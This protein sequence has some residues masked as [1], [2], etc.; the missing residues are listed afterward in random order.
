MTRPRLVLL[1]SVLAVVGIALAAVLDPDSRAEGWLRGEPFYHGRSASAW[2]HDLAQPDENGRA[3]ALKDLVDGKA[4]AVPVLAAVL[5]AGGETEARWRVID[6]LGQIGAEAREAGPELVPALEDPDPVVQRVAA[7]TLEKLAPHVPDAVPALVKVFPR[8]EAIRAVARYGTKGEEAVPPLI[9]L[10]KHPDPEVRWNAARAL[11]KLG[12]TGEPSIP[13][14]VAAM[15]SDN[16]VLVREH[17]AEALGD[18]GPR[19]AVAVP[20]LVKALSDREAQV[21]RDAVRALGQ[22][23]PAAKDALSAVRLRKKDDNEKVR[24]AAERAER[25]IDPA[26]PVTGKGGEKRPVEPVD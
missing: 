24:D 10:L 25:L 19:A 21:R 8:V 17:A 3:K 12:P 14:L 26:T 5:R 15:A 7:R 6:A 13:A 22:M 20:D 16:D 9:G 2:R 18:I 1:V 23:G 4:E 11:G